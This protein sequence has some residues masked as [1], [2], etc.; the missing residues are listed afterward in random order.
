M[1]PSARP[2][3]GHY[4]ALRRET[5]WRRWLSALLLAGATGLVTNLV[6]P[7]PL[8]VLSAVI[9]LAVLLLWDR[10]HGTLSD[11]WP[12]RS[13]AHRLAA[14]AAR[15][16]RQ[17]WSAVP[18]PAR[19]DD[20]RPLAAYLLIGPGGVF[21]LDHQVWWA[22]DAIGTDPATGL[23][24]VGGKPAARRVASV[25]GAAATVAHTLA[26]HLPDPSAVH[27]V[28]TVDSPMLHHPHLIAGVTIL[29]IAD[30]PTFLRDRDPLLHPTG[31]ST[32][33]EHARRNYPS[34]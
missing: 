28:L 6:L 3:A 31:I 20:A 9:A 19:P 11:C 13:R 24:M 34:T 26:N 23:L 10:R 4:A 22:T 7:W 29:P 33:T 32:L 1:N 2:A 18:A 21:V 25:K 8:A 30:L 12:G 14:T 16:E 15:L 27:P 17:G 5:L